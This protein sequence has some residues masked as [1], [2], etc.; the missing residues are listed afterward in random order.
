MLNREILNELL[1]KYD[2]RVDKN[3]VPTSLVKVNFAGDHSLCY[4]CDIDAIKKGD[5]VTV[6]GKL[7]DVTGVVENVLTSF[8]IP[9]FEMRWIESIVDNDISGKYFRL[10]NDMIS[11]NSALTVEKFVALYM[12]KKYKENTAYGENNVEISVCDAQNCELFDREVIKE[13]GREIYK[14]DGVEF[15][16]L[17]NGVGKV[18]V[19]GNDYYE[20]DFRYENGKITYLV[21]E[22]PYFDACK[23]EYAFLLKFKEILEKIKERT[24]TE[25]FV[26]VNNDCFN[27]IMCCAKGEVSMG[28]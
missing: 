13:R 26:V 25:N 11:F 12:R 2:E 20:L 16:W 8:K 21:C 9:K 17:Q 23:H 6:E 3:R 10:E 1:D 24:D 27:F 5:V 14:D 4:L 15:I 28:L 22:C 7:E 18:I 19:Y